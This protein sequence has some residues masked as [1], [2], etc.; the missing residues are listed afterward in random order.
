M[1]KPLG[2]VVYDAYVKEKMA[3]EARQGLKFATENAAKMHARYSVI[4]EQSASATGKSRGRRTII[5][6]GSGFCGRGAKICA[7]RSGKR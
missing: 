5:R 4:M 6:V 3:Q 2:V 1:A 7:A